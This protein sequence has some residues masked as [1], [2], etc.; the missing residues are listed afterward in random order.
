MGHQGLTSEYK[1]LMPTRTSA[2][3]LQPKKTSTSS[4]HSCTYSRRCLC[5]STTSHTHWLKGKKATC[6]CRRFTSS[7]QV[8]YRI[9][10]NDRSAY[11]DKDHPEGQFSILRST[12]STDQT[13]TEQ[14][15][16]SLAISHKHHVRSEKKTRRTSCTH[17][18]QHKTI[19]LHWSASK[20]PARIFT[21]YL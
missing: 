8:G 12:T 20:T 6:S 11:L 10:K 4:C 19:T 17:R 1:V 9:E 16:L 15:T 5:K 13:Q 18:T 3:A 14:S 2:L 21:S 7:S